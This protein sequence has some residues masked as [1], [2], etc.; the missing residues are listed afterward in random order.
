[1]SNGSP[2]RR[3]ATV[4]AMGLLGALLVSCGT[5]STSPP[6]STA[7][8][9][10]TGSSLPNV[11]LADLD[12]A[13]VPLQSLANGTP[14]VLNFWYSTCP[15]CKQEMPALGALATEFTG[16]VTFVGINPQDDASTAAR[17][18]AERDTTYRQLLDR[19]QR[20][21]DA[22]GLTGFPTTVLVS[23]DGSIVGTYRK[24]FTEDELR[25]LINET[26]LP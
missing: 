21:V 4:I 17:I 2:T 20:G 24:S 14:V 12:G 23:G 3:L 16:R 15:P 1:V 11:F 26:L 9:S 10:A 6:A 5:R 13:T 7:D 22:L 25:V 18:A 8:H 19:T